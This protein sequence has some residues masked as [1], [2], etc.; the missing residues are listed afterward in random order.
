MRAA[1]ENSALRANPPQRALILPQLAHCCAHRRQHAAAAVMTRHAAQFSRS[2]REP[3]D[4]EPR[5]MVSA[6]ANDGY[7]NPCRLPKPPPA[8]SC[9]RTGCAAAAAAPARVGA[10]PGAPGRVDSTQPAS[11]RPAAPFA[12]NVAGDV[13]AG[14]A[15]PTRSTSFGEFRLF[16]AAPQ[17]SQTARRIACFCDVCVSGGSLFAR[18]GSVRVL[19]PQWIEVDCKWIALDAVQH[20]TEVDRLALSGSTSGPLPVQSDLAVGR[21]R[22]RSGPEVDRSGPEVDRS[23]PKWTKAIS[24]RRE[25]ESKQTY[26]TACTAT[27]CG[28]ILRCERH[29]AKYK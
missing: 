7:A 8:C 23:G 2:W 1:R 27:C 12:T 26:S 25:R 28:S 17:T 15:A 4:P 24:A 5:V 18:A 3:M 29:G 22:K 14:A 6:T 21:S 10:C 9:Q 16:H 13:A 11:I 20:W 19:R